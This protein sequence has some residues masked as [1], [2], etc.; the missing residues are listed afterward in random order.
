[1]SIERWK[2]Y[3]P[4]IDPTAFVHANA[5]VIGDV[6]IGSESSIWPGAVL[7]GDDGAIVIGPRTS[8]Q[9]LSVIHAT[10]GWSKTTIGAR[11]TVGH[12]VILHG[13]TVEDD[14]LIGMGAILLD[15][16]VVGRGS[17]IGAGALVKV[18]EVIPPGSF[19]LGMPA[20]VVRACGEKER[21]MIEMGWREYVERTHEY[22]E[23]DAAR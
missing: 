7:R 22:R 6:S 4:R 23:R 19:V 21:A 8:I 16:C 17:F 5:T 18:G 2:E 14:C 9:D 1:M 20:K 3:T 12:R 13:C 10:T 11:V 15:N